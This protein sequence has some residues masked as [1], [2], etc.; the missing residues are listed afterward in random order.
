MNVLISSAGRRGA[1][2]RIIKE[3]IANVGGKVFA[4]DAGRWS[5]ACRLADGWGQVPRCTDNSFCKHLRSYAHD[6]DVKL[7]IPTIDTELA[8]L[9]QHREF[10][11]D[12]GVHVAV[13]GPATIKIAADKIATHEFLKSLGLPVIEHFDVASTAEDLPYPLIIKPRFGSASAGVHILEDAEA[14]TFYRKRVELPVLQSLAPGKEYTVNFFADGK[15]GCL[16]EVPHLRVET[17]GGEVSKCVTVKEPR[18][19]QIA[20]ELCKHLPDAW[21]PLCYQAFIDDIGT[22]RIIELNARFGGGYPIA[23]YAGADF[24][25]PLLRIGSGLPLQ[26]GPL[27]WQ[28]G[29]VMTRWDDAVF[30][31]AQEVGLCA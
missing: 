15:G 25:S 3:S 28:G 13:S 17:R 14:C 30:T 29:I 10:F 12:A 5:S 2:V 23:H 7:I 18:L 22:V 9:S 24:V 31:T 20:Q 16:A 1:L 19:M 6:H 4:V 8:I 11:S 27:H 26:E 21:G